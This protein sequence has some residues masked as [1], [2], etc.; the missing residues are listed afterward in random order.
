LVALSVCPHAPVHIWKLPP[1]ER[2]PTQHVQLLSPRH[3]VSWLQHLLFEHCVH[4]LSPPIGAHTPPPDELLE[5]DVEVL[6]PHGAAHFW[7]AQLMYVL[8]VAS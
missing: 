1:C 5:L 2:H 8:V 4:W 7:T 6:P 3:A